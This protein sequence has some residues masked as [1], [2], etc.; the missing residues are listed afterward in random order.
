MKFSIASVALLVG[1]VNA[2]T[3]SSNKMFGVR[4]KSSSLDMA[5]GGSL[6]VKPIGIGS[7]APATVVTNVDLENVVET[8]DEWIQT[9]TG[10]AERHLLVDGETIVDVST[11]AAQ[12][13]LDMSGLDPMDIDIVIC[14]TS[15]PE[16]LF[17]D[18][19]TIAA[20]LGC[21]NAVAYDLVA[22]CSGFL[23]G[24]VTAA[25]FLNNGQ[26]NAIVI[27]S[28]AL[29]RWTDWDDRNSC[30]LFGD[31][32]GAMVYT[33]SEEPA[34]LG[35]SMHSKGES[36]DELKC[37]YSGTPRP[38]DTPGDGTVLSSGS[39]S[40]TTM[41]GKEVYK[42]ATREV[43]RVV[44]EALVEA[45][46]TVDDVDWLLLHQA[47]IRIMETVA[48]RLKIPMDKVI[49]NL[50]KYGNTSAA[51]I[52]LAFDEAVRSGQVKKGDIIACSGFGAGLSW[53]SVIMRWEGEEEN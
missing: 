22:A 49:T 4:T 24:S 7:A 11:K 45:D 42:F 3:P 12:N 51:S 8:S 43:P 15:S 29:S 23:F 40:K 33:A 53:G 5:S 6:N 47:N 52:P 21:K 31:G 28:D 38:I 20:N 9:R 46:L 18:A 19:T 48:S 44:K 50:S 41:N 10:I 37:M 1:A 2:F 13:A 36:H 35:Y 32:A 34:F 27:G 25:Q 30:I 26:K 16:D 17:G 14:A 39:Y